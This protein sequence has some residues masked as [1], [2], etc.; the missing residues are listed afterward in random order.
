MFVG[1]LWG[2]ERKVK[3]DA[4]VRGGVEERHSANIDAGSDL[5]EDLLG[6]CNDSRSFSLR[7]GFRNRA[8]HSSVR[9][10]MRTSFLAG[11]RTL[12]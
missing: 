6:R 5:L 8:T 12:V 9:S 10:A 11:G 1:T 4:R 7:L 3:R 2:R